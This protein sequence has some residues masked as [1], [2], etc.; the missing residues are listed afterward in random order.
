MESGHSGHPLWSR[1][2][3]LMMDDFPSAPSSEDRFS[4]H[5]PL[6]SQKTIILEV[7]G[8]A[9]KGICAFFFCFVFTFTS[10]HERAA[11][12][13]FLPG[14]NHALGWMRPMSV[15][16]KNENNYLSVIFMCTG[17]VPK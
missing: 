17:C 4:S 11:A 10:S 13:C 8:L 1:Q 2:V 16:C 12:L 7:I 6:C 14:C 3:L 15:K 5:V 9:C